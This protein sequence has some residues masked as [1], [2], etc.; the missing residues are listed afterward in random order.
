MCLA[1]GTRVPGTVKK[2]AAMA[3]YPGVTVAGWGQYRVKGSGHKVAGTG[4]C[5]RQRAMD[6]CC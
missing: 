2:K 6:V 3:V 4:E 5:H 1:Q